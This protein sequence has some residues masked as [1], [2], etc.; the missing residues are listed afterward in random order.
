MEAKNRFVS[1]LSWT[2]VIKIMQM[3][4]QLV[5]G[6]LIARFLGP[7][8]YGTIN[9]VASFVSF[10]TAI[11]SLGISGVIV[12]EICDHEDYENKIVGTAITI[13]FVL[14]FI[15]VICVLVLILTVNPGE[16]SIFV[17]AILESVALLFACFDTINYWYQAHHKIKIAAVVQFVAYSIVALYKIILLICKA[18]IIWFAFSTSLDVICVAVLYS[19]L[20]FKSTHKELLC[21][22]KTIAYDLVKKSMP[23]L[24]ANIMIIVYQQIDKIMLGKMLDQ[25]TVGYYSAVT[26]VCNMWAIVPASFLDVMRP[27]IM[28]AKGT[29]E[30]QYEKRMVET[31]WGLI[32]INV[33]FSF[34]VTVFAKLIIWILYGAEYF[35]AVNTLRLVVWYSTFSYIGSGRSVYLICEGKN[36]Y[37]QIF[38]AW[39]AVIDI[40]LNF[41]LIPILGING[42]AIATIFTHV[43]SDFL[44]PGFYKDTRGYCSFVI[45]GVKAWDYM[46]QEYQSYRLKRNK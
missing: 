38:C 26:T 20:Y 43:F 37:A 5:I 13:R 18:N 3:V 41:L 35:P 7:T 44:I 29:D 30:A 31:F 33:L 28:S 6:M 17:I 45:R 16:T 10:A 21:F 12:K 15:S 11:V 39:G 4:L 9:Y 25:T 40:V 34:G 23:F 24:V 1:N 46:L 2:L 32:Y 36:R 42:A 22:D 19:Y 14:G 27:I 8:G